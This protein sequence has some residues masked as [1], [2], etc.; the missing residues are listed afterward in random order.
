MKKE[1]INE[2]LRI[3]VLSN[4]DTKNTFTE[5]QGVILER[6]TAKTL[7]QDARYLEALRMELDDILRTTGSLGA[8]G[9]FKTADD[10][11]FALKNQSMS[12]ADLGK[13][14]RAILKNSKNPTL[15]KTA[16]G[17]V[18]STETFSKAFSSGTATQRLAKLKELNPNMSDDMLKDLHAAN[19]L[20]L[21]N[22]SKSGKGPK[23]KPNPKSDK[24]VFVANPDGPPLMFKNEDE[25]LKWLKKQKNPKPITGGGTGGA[26]QGD[27]I[28]NQTFHIDGKTFKN[29]DD[30][31]KYMN[32]YGDD[33]AKQNG[34]YFDDFAKQNGHDD[35]ISWMRKNPDE[36]TRAWVKEGR[37]GK[38]VFAKFI[39]WGKRTITW[40]LLWGLAK[41][42]AVGYGIWWLYDALKK[43]DIDTICEEQGMC[44]AGQGKG[45]LPCKK[46]DDDDNKDDDNKDEG[47]GGGGIV[48]QDGNKYIECDPPFYK[49]C[50]GKKGNTDIQKAQECLGVTPNGFFN[51]QTEDALYKKINK[52]NFSSSDMSN[53]CARSLG[54]SGFEI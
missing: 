38:G 15:R 20:R 35:W 31:I 21:K 9:M 49:G 23:P 54:S 44:W 36:A 45:C 16:A 39:N 30:Y 41:L 12:V 10:V 29:Q 24:P 26:K 14:N 2:I 8:K 34:R 17:W 4:Y 46:D 28:I 32:Q 48:D 53:I 13:L 52:K 7:A 19:E 27:T 33:F 22:L 25:Y 42:A 3:Q 6:T 5:N 43:E 18:V 40:K 50:V 1:L 51:Q 11:I 37:S 47:G